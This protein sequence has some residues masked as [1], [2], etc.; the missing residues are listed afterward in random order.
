MN[1]SRSGYRDYMNVVYASE[2]ITLQIVVFARISDVLGS[3]LYRHQPVQAPARLPDI[4]GSEVSRK[5]SSRDAAPSLLHRR[6]RLRQHGAGPR[7]P[8]HA[9]HVRCSP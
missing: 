5:A 1:A 9:H 2:K 6:Q 8:V 3:V 7:E 4:G